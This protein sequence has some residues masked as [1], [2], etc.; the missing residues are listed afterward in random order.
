MDRKM[1]LALFFF[2]S[3]VLAQPVKAPNFSLKTSD[4]KT[5][6]LA[7]FKGKAVVVNFWATW[8]PP[9][10]EEIPDFIE[11]YKKYE[12]QGLVLIGVS[13]DQEGWEV[14]K[15]FVEKMKIPYPVVIGNQTVVRHYGNFDG[16]PATFFINSDGNIVDQQ[17]GM[18]TKDI[19]EA[20]VKAI[21]PKPKETPKQKESP[22]N[23]EK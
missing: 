19:F 20:K 9:C 1:F 2:A 22:K 18:L 14:V 5:I 13:L 8:C 4:G 3:T 21:I 15:P 6:E 17:I 7:Q 16:I 11:V 12:K 23:K 10:K